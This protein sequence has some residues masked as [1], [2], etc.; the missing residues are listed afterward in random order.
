MNYYFSKLL[1]FLGYRKV[2]YYPSDK[3]LGIG[4][5]YKWEYKPNAR[6]DK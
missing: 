5:F 2:W 4:D 3:G 1:Y 6:F